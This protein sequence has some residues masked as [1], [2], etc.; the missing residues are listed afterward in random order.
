MHAACIGCKFNAWRR[1]P[2]CMHYASSVA[3]SIEIHVSRRRRRVQGVD[4]LHPGVDALHTGVDA[5]HAGLFYAENCSYFSERVFLFLD[6]IVNVV[7]II[8]MSS[9]TLIC[10]HVLIAN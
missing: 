4:A 3:A 9:A 8:A 5:L 1:R 6:V 2:A 10:R 7:M